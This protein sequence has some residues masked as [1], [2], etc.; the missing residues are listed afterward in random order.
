MP[1]TYENMSCD[2]LKEEL[3]HIQKMKLI[4]TRKK[5][6]LEETAIQYGPA[7]PIDVQ[8]QLSELPKSILNYQQ[9]IEKLTDLIKQQCEPGVP[10]P[11]PVPRTLTIL[12]CCADPIDAVRLRLMREASEIQDRLQNSEK[13][14]LVTE[15]T[16]QPGNI[17]RKM[18]QANPQ[19]VHFSGHGSKKGELIFEDHN[20]NATPVTPAAI[21]NLFKQFADTLQCVVLNACY[22]YQT[23]QEIA[24]HIHYVVAMKTAISDEAALAFSVGFYQAIG[25]DKSIPDAFEFGKVQIQLM[26]I[27]EELTPVLITK[28]V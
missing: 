9:E 24:K 11:G 17:A 19:F 13:F 2:D 15:L 26:N 12:L 4:A 23:A 20:G 21:T 28:G 22:S 3:E 6:L 18:L 27:P 5:Y 25:A 10:P 14:R 7:I 1:N 16:T 8:I